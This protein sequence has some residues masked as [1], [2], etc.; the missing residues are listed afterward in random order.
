[1]RKSGHIFEGGKT[2]DTKKI[3]Q[4]HGGDAD[5]VRVAEPILD[6]AKKEAEEQAQK[7]GGIPAMVFF[8]NKWESEAALAYDQLH[9]KYKEDLGLDALPVLTAAPADIT[10]TG[11]GQVCNPSDFHYYERNPDNSV[12]PT[13]MDL[14]K[15][16]LGRVRLKRRGQAIYQWY[17][18]YYKRLGEADLQTLIHRQLEQELKVAGTA[19]QLRGVQIFL[20]SDAA[21]EDI[22]LEGEDTPLLCVAN[23]L[24]DMRTFALYPHS[25]QY[26]F[27]SRLAVDWHGMQACPLFDAFLWTIAGGDQLLIRRIWQVLG[28]ILVP[29]NRAKRLIILQGVGDSGKSVLGN[30]IQSFFDEDAV[31]NLD[32]FRF[33]ERFAL[34]TLADKRLNISMDLPAGELSESAVAA[35]KELT[36][37]DPV[38]IEE[39]YKA[40]RSAVITCSLVFGTNHQLRLSSPDDAFLNRVLLVPFR[41]AVPKSQQDPTL[42]EKLTQ[43][44]SGILYHALT[45]YHEVAQSQ[46][47]YVFAGDDYFTFDTQV[48]E[49]HLRIPESVQ[50]FVKHYCIAADNFTPTEVLYSAYLKVSGHEG[51]APISD[52]AAFSRQL[53]LICGDR[54]VR[55]KQRINGIPTNGYC[56]IA[57]KEGGGVDA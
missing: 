55:K 25:S 13:V 35:L 38:T 36:G 10:T 41:H 19:S 16:L 43:E 54:I 47:A 17:D 24:L 48:G 49:T 34:S 28:Y 5:L 40:P 39:K 7:A 44:R 32:I 15:M 22:P 50:A 9:L 4:V 31:A 8:K 53:S 37:R 42:F 57:L 20:Q 21:I 23:G 33:R 2:L 51:F 6:R 56:G 26:F 46:G 11:L 27:T 3:V 14:E 1:M 18:G 30:L 52:A 12:G 29:D 45:A